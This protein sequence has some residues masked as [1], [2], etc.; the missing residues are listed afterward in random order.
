[1]KTFRWRNMKHKTIVPLE[2]FLISRSKTSNAE[3]DRTATG[4]DCLYCIHLFHNKDMWLC[5]EHCNKTSVLKEGEL[6]DR[7]NLHI[8]LTMHH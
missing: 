7:M 4:E 3:N 5:R 8:C 6:F 1:M 2:K